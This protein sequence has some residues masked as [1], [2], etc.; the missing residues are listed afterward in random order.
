MRK[1][2]GKLPELEEGVRPTECALPGKNVCALDPDIKYMREFLV[3]TTP[4]AAHWSS[5]KVVMELKKLL[6]VPTESAIWESEAFRSF[7]GEGK[8]DEVLKSRYKP[9]GPGRSTALLDNFNIDETLD[10]WSEHGKSIFKRRFYHI[11]YQM[12]DFATT[13]TELATLDIKSLMDQKYDCFGVVLNTDV[14]T[15]PGKHWFCIF[16]DLQHKGSKEDPIRIEFFNSSGNP[17]TSEVNVWLEKTEHDLLRDHGIHTE[18]VRSAP[19]R[20]QNSQTECGV[21]SLLYIKSRLEG[22]PP[23]WFYK[24]KATDKDMIEYRKF[25]FRAQPG[26]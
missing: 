21:W 26:H 13:G 5:T 3:S 11:P 25:L 1:T 2:G 20:L 22:H 19:R 8:A 18:I 4:E 15:G 16:G 14:S 12:I 7:I 23:N 6:D 9:R 17:P 10:Q 24:V